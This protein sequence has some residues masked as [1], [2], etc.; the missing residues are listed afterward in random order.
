MSKLNINDANSVN[1]NVE[2]NSN[3]ICPNCG[4][5]DISYNEKDGTLVCNY[6]RKKFEIKKARTYEID[7]IKNIQGDM[8][9][10]GT[11][12]ITDFNNLVTLKCDNCGAEVIV[13]TSESL[14]ARCHWCRSTLSVS[15]KVPNGSVPDMILPFNV[16][17]EV[18]FKLMSDYTRKYKFYAKKGFK[19]QL[20]IENIVGV[21]FPYMVVDIN[22][23]VKLKGKGEHQTR[24]YTDSD[25]NV[26]YNADL[27]DVGRECDLFI[28]D[29]TIE[30]NSDKI[31]I[32]KKDKTNN[33]INAI[34]PFDTENC[35]DWNANYLKGYNSE[36]RDLNIG[37]LKNIV[38]NQA[39]NIAKRSVNS[40]LRFYDRGVRWEEENVD[41][42]GRG[43]KTAYL[44]VW[45]Y[46]YQEKDRKGNITK[47]YYV[48]VN[49]R[50]TET[51]GSIPL[52][53]KKLYLLISLIILLFPI[54]QLIII[55]SIVDKDI[56]V[57][58]G[59]LPTIMLG[60]SFIILE[61]IKYRNLSERHYYEKETR[62]KTEN[63]KCFD[64]FLKK[65][66]GLNSSRI[67]GENNLEIENYL[68]PTEKKNKIKK[69]ISNIFFVFVLVIA[70]I[71]LF[72]S[73]MH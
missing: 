59:L 2:L 4:S 38:T 64:K 37:E 34:M 67:E 51:K 17:K 24:R 57:L 69:D 66:Y 5:T 35:L 26:N 49:G 58:L 48:A 47:E 41:I 7:E 10:S 14:Q 40:T 19:D 42:K 25:Q 11:K 39:E 36:K 8:I 33:I 22:T 15:K 23:H 9:G 65:E 45:L 21:Y 32:R 29:L 56:F 52:S 6:C 18:A 13:D 43:W 62:Y 70:F 12:N 46:N 54:N 50:T 16:S 31:D 44:P 68:F 55:D 53:N 61:K 27:Y 71:I 28:D 60:L 30:S 1:K 3:S 20:K 72:Y 73:K 63:I